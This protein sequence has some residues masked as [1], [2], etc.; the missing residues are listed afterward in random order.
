MGMQLPPEIVHIQPHPIFD[1]CL[2]WPKSWMDQ[3]TTWYGGKRR[4]RRRCV[5]WGRSSPLKGAHPP[6]FGSCLLWPNGWMDD[7]ATWYGSRPRARP[8]C[9]RRGPSSPRKGHSSPPLFGPRVLLPRSAVSVTDE[10]LFIKKLPVAW[11][12][13]RYGV[14]ARTVTKHW[15]LYYRQWRQGVDNIGGNSLYVRA[16]CQKTQESQAE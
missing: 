4:P 15:V 5:R 1:P 3:D 6:V 12:R 13:C 10:L 2:L 11:K 7:D 9:V 8:H 14:P 16:V